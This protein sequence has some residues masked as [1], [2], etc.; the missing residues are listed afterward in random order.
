MQPLPSFSAANPS[1]RRLTDWAETLI[2]LKKRIKDIMAGVTDKS[3]YMPIVQAAYTRAFQSHPCLSRF[4][5]FQQRLLSTELDFLV[6]SIMNKCRSAI[7]EVIK[8]TLQN[9]HSNVPGGDVMEQLKGC[10]RNYIIRHIVEELKMKPL[11]LQPD[12]QCVED[13]GTVA[14][15][16]AL[17]LKIAH[18]NRASTAFTTIL[19]RDGPAD[20]V[21]DDPEQPGP[22][23]AAVMNSLQPIRPYVAPMEPI[24][25]MND[26]AGSPFAIVASAAAHHFGDE[27]DLE[28]AEG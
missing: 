15:R 9:M 11:Q 22:S 18:L 10:G 16:E 1:S 14:S 12:F 27:S 5:T 19:A 2:D 6:G 26:L 8:S 7:D 17:E 3:L 24:L 25:Q 21:A 23:D 13:E 20:P 4:G 28:D